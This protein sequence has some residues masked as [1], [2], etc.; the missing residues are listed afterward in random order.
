MRA[1]T[2]AVFV[3]LMALAALVAPAAAQ[4][5]IGIG[6]PRVGV[7]I[8]F[9]TPDYPQLQLVPGYPVYYAPG[10]NANYFYYDG[11]FWILQGDN[12]YSSAW[13]NGPWQG[14]GPG[15]VPDFILRVPVGYYIHPPGFFLNWQ[16]DAP[17]H[18][19]E[20][21]GTGWAQRRG[22][23][24]RWDQ[25]SMPAAAPPPSYQQRYAGAHYPRP[26]QQGELR[27][28]QDHYQPRDPVVRRVMDA[29][30][31]RAS[32]RQRPQSS[33]TPA[34]PSQQQQRVP[35]APR[36]QAKAPAPQ[37]QRGPESRGPQAGT[38]QPPAQQH[39]AESGPAQGREGEAHDEGRGE[40]RR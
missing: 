21:W 4:I 24:D 26:E 13:Y 11:M 14:V 36:A 15:D 6:L 22:G 8:G 12:W 37:Q 2:A 1:G 34:P 19:G 30:Q 32:E 9:D 27:H 29:Q 39:R 28:Q 7:D 17:P 16:R 25:R 10:L 20:H 5:S 3:A 33:S 35:E 23:W 31:P 38:G 18:W 40:G